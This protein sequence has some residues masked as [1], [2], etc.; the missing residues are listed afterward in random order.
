MAYV[1]AV[2][3]LIVAAGVIGFALKERGRKRRSK[4]E[5]AARI[6]DEFYTS[7]RTSMESFIQAGK[8]PVYSNQEWL[9]Q[10][11]PNPAAEHLNP[12]VIYYKSN[13][14]AFQSACDWMDCSLEELKIIPALVERASLTND[15][16]QMCTLKL[17]SKEGGRPILFCTTIE[18]R[19]PELKVGDL[20]AFQV[21]GFNPEWRS[22]VFGCAGFIVA[23]LEP[24][25]SIKR[26]WKVCRGRVASP[27]RE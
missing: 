21:G 19:F 3:I 4:V 2:V 1:L 18:R 25:L 26:G 5:T 6:F 10:T 23:K 27:P 16:F 24:A 13:D 17:A 12:D 8:I 22:T 20:V 14:D 7:L 9:Q 15:G 11:A